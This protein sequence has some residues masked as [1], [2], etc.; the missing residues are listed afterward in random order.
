MEYFFGSLVLAFN[1]DKVLSGSCRPSSYQISVSSFHRAVASLNTPYI[2]VNPNV[3]Q[4]ETIKANPIFDYQLYFQEPVS[5]GPREQWSQQ[6]I[7]LL[8]SFSPSPIGL[9]YLCPLSFSVA[10]FRNDFT[11]GLRWNWFW[12]SDGPFHV[13]T[14][15]WGT[16]VG[17]MACWVLL[18]L[19]NC[20]VGAWALVWSWSLLGLW[21]R[22]WRNPCLSG[23]ASDFLPGTWYCGFLRSKVCDYREHQNL[24][25]L[26][27]APGMLREM[28]GVSSVTP[29]TTK[30]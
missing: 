21:L 20:G 5:L 29:C 2:A 10:L 25:A 11:N 17:T 16:G 15:F 12:S 6:G 7:A 14:H 3:P 18:L 4:I 9:I 26:Y 24:K 13:M 22:G 27:P 19:W 30:L 28:W 1:W 23:T 8:S